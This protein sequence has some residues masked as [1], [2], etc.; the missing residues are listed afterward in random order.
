MEKKLLNVV[1]LV[2][3]GISLVHGQRT[4][5]S[6][7]SATDPSC[8]TL[9]ITPL[10]TKT[11]T[12]ATDSCVSAI[13]GERTVRGCLAD[14][15]GG[16]CSG[17]LCESCGANNCNAGIFPLN[18]AQCHK[19]AGAECAEVTNNDYLTVCER[20]VENDS[21]YSVVVDE[22]LLLTY[23]GCASEPTTDVGRQECTRLDEQGFCVTCTAAGCNNQAAKAP[24]QLNC[25]KCDGDTSCR[26]KQP[27]DFGLPCYYDVILGRTEYCYSYI[28]NNNRVSRGCLDDEFV[29]E[30]NYRE[31]CEANPETCTLCA[32]NLCNYENYA[33]HTC[34]SCDGH[35]DPNCDT[36][37]GWYEAQECPGGTI[38]Q[39]GCFTATTDGVTMRGCVSQLHPDEVTYCSNPQVSSCTLC[40]ANGCNGR[41]PKTCITCDSSNDPNCA[42]VADPQ[43]LTQYSQECSSSSAIC[44]SRISNGYTQRGCSGTIS[45]TSGNPCMQCDGPN[46]NNDV[47]PTDRLKCHKCSGANCADIT[48]NTNLEVC[49]MYNVNDQCFTVVTDEE[50]THRGCYSDPSSST[51][52]SVCTQHE[53]GQ[54]R[55]VKC[56]GEGCNTQAIKT[57][58]THSCVKCTGAGCSE[59]Q[60]STP[61]EACFGDVL[62]GRTEQC[63][64]Y[65]YDNGNIQRGCLYDPSTPQA[66]STECSNSPGG[67]CKV[68]DGANC[69]TEE[70]TITE[71]CY[72]C[73][74]ELN[75]GCATMTGTIETKQCPIGTLLGC[76]R[77]QVDGIV[78]RGCAGELV[79]GE[80]TLCQ[81]GAQCK[82][83]DG[84]NC[85]EKVD[86]QRC[87]SCNSANNGASCYNAQD[88]ANQA[89]C[90]DYMDSCIVAIGSNGETLRGCASAYSSQ[91]PICS[92]STCQIC[93]DGYCNG[94]VFP[95]D[96]ARC[97]QCSGSDTCAGSLGSGSDTLQLCS[98]YT[99]ND[100]CYSVAA[101]QEMHRGC[102]S[103]STNGNT[104]CNSAGG[105]CVTCS[106]AGCNSQAGRSNPTLSCVK[107]SA[108]D[109]ACLWGFGSNSA[110]PCTNQVWLGSTESC[111]RAQTSSGANRGCTLDNPNQCPDSSSCTTCSQNG[112]NTATFARQECLRCKSD[113]E[114]EENCGPEPDE[115]SSTQCEAGGD[116][117]YEKRGCYLLVDDDGLVTR[118]C[119]KD[120]SDSSLAECKDDDNESCQYCED[121]GCNRWAGASAIEAISFGAM[122]LIAVVAKVLN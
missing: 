80:I 103:D 12:T 8:A 105:S 122:L 40:D 119:A 15:F 121:N 72:S 70:I 34:F 24:S 36:L 17:E 90:S 64:S 107:C 4:C 78:V 113:V 50:V 55:C 117:S 67:R 118:G 31:L 39:V 96:R 86:F 66:I 102:R 88:T 11:C 68:C 65:I 115:Y 84:N 13:N 21:C 9:A 14:D 54:D 6:C 35:D 56:E 7:D 32:Y 111:F 42:T 28:G 95:A 93:P 41:P 81:R 100:Q 16:I 116:E 27:E 44:I 91:F 63:Y 108:T 51:A 74:S 82:L 79:S 61:G 22:N 110:Q 101:N 48:D 47:L 1:I 10:P 104:H 87:Y 97:H 60:D 57:P 75:P 5:H 85:N 49:E 98:T 20:Y 69:N 62:L 94:A 114:G 18:R 33:Y 120:L 77:S 26:Y 53:S 29:G 112:C 30:T 76:F 58:A 19:C 99:P 3:C 38:D 71:T 43:A 23:R 25:M 59:N 89:T 92:G 83:C 109:P 46:C 73:D 45:C 37:D 2:I 52:K 106:G